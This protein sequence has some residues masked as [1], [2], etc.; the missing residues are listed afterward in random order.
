M[1]TIYTYLMNVGKL[2]WLLASS[3]FVFFIVSVNNEWNY[4]LD[5]EA[6]RNIN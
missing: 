2:L 5:F 1:Y 3:M 4:G 6:N